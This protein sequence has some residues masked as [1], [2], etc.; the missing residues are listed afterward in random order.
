MHFICVLSR[1]QY[2]SSPVIFVSGS[3]FSGRSVARPGWR[4]KWTVVD[5]VNWWTSCALV[6]LSVSL[7]VC[8]RVRVCVSVKYRWLERTTDRGS[9][10]PPQPHP[11]ISSGCTTTQTH[12]KNFRVRVS[13]RLVSF[14]TF[15]SRNH[16]N[17]PGE[18]VIRR[19][20]PTPADPTGKMYHHQYF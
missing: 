9:V 2:G 19:G 10:R 18:R 20:F 1:R 15:N 11:H 13:K 12:K 8:L 7:S 6:C 17:V 14:F 4:M 3:F 16:E 5:H